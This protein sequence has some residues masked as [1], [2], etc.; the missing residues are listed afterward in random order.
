MFSKL[1][2]GTRKALTFDSRDRDTNSVPV[3]LYPLLYLGEN[4]QVLQDNRILG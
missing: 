4:S 1:P 3:F 2:A